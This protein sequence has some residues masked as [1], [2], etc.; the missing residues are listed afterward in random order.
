MGD[1]WAKTQ[2]DGEDKILGYM[3]VKREQTEKRKQRQKEMDELDEFL[4]ED[5]DAEILTSRKSESVKG[6]K[7]LSDTK[8]EYENQ[9][10]ENI[11]ETLQPFG[12]FLLI[13]AI[14]GAW[15]YKASVKAKL[16]I[17]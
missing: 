14:L 15:L 7:I 4:G 9:V 8:Q 2:E 3:K 6:G 10:T 17:R 12:I 1:G 11:W 5:P 13:I 16:R